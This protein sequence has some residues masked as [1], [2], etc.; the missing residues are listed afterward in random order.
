MVPSIVLSKLRSNHHGSHSSST[1]L[2]DHTSLPPLQTSMQENGLDR[3]AHPAVSKNKSPGVRISSSESPHDESSASQL[4][5]LP[6]SSEDRHLHQPSSVTSER[7]GIV[8]NGTIS[9]VASR[10]HNFVFSLQPPRKFTPSLSPNDYP[11]SSPHTGQVQVYGDRV[12]SKN[13]STS[14]LSAADDAATHKAGPSRLAKGKFNLFNPLSLLA[15]RRSSQSQVTKLEDANPNVS[16]LHVP[17]LPDDYDPRIRGKIIHDFSIP[18]ARRFDSYN[19][20]PSAETSPSI[21]SYPSTQDNRKGSEQSLHI[22]SLAGRVP[23]SPS[24]SPMFKEHFNDEKLS[25]QPQNTGYLHTLAPH[26]VTKTADEAPKLPAFAKILPLDVFGEDHAEKYSADKDSTQTTSDSNV[27]LGGPRITMTKSVEECA[28]CNSPVVQALSSSSL[29]SPKNRSSPTCEFLRPVESLPKHMSSTSSRFSFQLSGIGSETEERLLEEKHKLH[30]ALKRS[31]VDDR[32]DLDSEEDRYANADFDDDDDDRLEEKIPGINADLEDE[33]EVATQHLCLEIVKLEPLAD[34]DDDAGFEESIPGVNADLD[35]ELA[36][37][38]QYLSFNNVRVTSLSAETNQGSVNPSSRELDSNYGADSAVS[39][40]PALMPL[41]SN[42]HPKAL[43]QLPCSE[44]FGATPLSDQ[45]SPGWNENLKQVPQHS[46]NEGEDTDDLYFDDGNFAGIEDASENESFDEDIFDDET[47]MIHNIPAQNALRV[48]FAQE[49]NMVLPCRLA[50][51]P[52]VMETAAVD[53]HSQDSS[54]STSDEYDILP[55]PS[56]AQDRKQNFS[57][58]GEGQI[59]GLTEDNLAYQNALVSAANKAAAQGRFS[60]H[61][62]MSLDS[63]DISSKSQIA[64]SQPGLTSDDSRI[65]RLFENAIAEDDPRDFPFDDSMEDDPMI[66]EANA[67]VLENDEDGFYGQEF[68]FYARA[69]G[70]GASEM[71]NGGYFGPRGVEGVQRSHSAKAHFQE[72][73]LT[74]ITERSEWS[75]RNSIVSINTLGLPLLAQPVAS[76]GIAQLLER[77]PSGLEDDI[78]LSA[79]L[80]LRR[81][82]WGGSQTSLNSSGGSQAGSSPLGQP[83]LIDSVRSQ[84]ADL[85]NDAPGGRCLQRHSYESI[86]LLSEEFEDER[87]DANSAATELQ[88]G[89]STRSSG[90]RSQQAG[91]DPPK[92]PQYLPLLS[93]A[94]EK[95]VKG[96]SRASSGAESVSYIR[97]PEGSGRWLLER[98]R[99]GDDGELELVGREYVAGARI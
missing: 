93:Q 19:G 90:D 1:H 39:S 13:L 88:G 54:P 40:N 60:R 92:H 79:L 57:V 86:P 95:S 9:S 75:H 12:S 8:A 98:R 26:D 23:Q 15:R 27:S 89:T 68:G 5:P 58:S 20:V 69:C 25:L 65:S 72:P 41:G 38:A 33:L 80:K 31:D 73:T 6:R 99:T 76:P 48:K 83:P 24:H 14:S 63:E 62:S 32:G 66:A 4:T 56:D 67:E 87:M 53:E 64:E 3:P 77:D 11:V 50:R 28:P 45:I 18:K 17:N 10:A 71:V 44:G 74:P 47:G 29:K 37:D 94:T 21:E 59:N 43:E 35:D 51:L 49:Q 55:H 70:K 78:S 81:G 7:P 52:G 85:E 42:F 82:A 46:G 16:T 36:M 96:H 97:D 61:L 2:Y 91:L 30:V 22:W 84:L 34:C